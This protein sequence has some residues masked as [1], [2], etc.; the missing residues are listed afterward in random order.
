MSVR[1][2]IEHALRSYYVDSAEPNAIAR[3]LLAQYDAERDEEKASAKAPT[4][5]PELLPKADVVAWLTKKAREQRA[6]GP[7]FVREA[8][9]ISVLASKAD[10]GAIRPDNLLMLPADF[11][12]PGH[13]YSDTDP[14]IDWKFRVDHITTHPENGELT[15]LGWR[16]FKGEWQPIAHFA[17]D[18]ELHQHVGHTA[19]EKSSRTAA[20]AT[21]QLV[22]R[23]AQLLDAIRTHRGEWT[24]KRVQ[25]LYRGTPLAPPQP[26]AGRFR[27]VARGDLRDLCAWGHLV[28]HDEKNRR[29]FTLATRNGSA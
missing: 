24:T 14:G 15:A 1:S 11:F 16:H 10:R 9:A 5:T 20:D 29:Y 21:P 3:D 22:G 25:D 8:D 12:E 28:M 17:D 7:H 26:P 6:R 18:W 13:T 4:A 19:V 27:E 23:V 2:V